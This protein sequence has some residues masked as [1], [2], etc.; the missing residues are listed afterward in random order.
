[1][2]RYISLQSPS[3]W[4]LWLQELT[5]HSCPCLP[6]SWVLAALPGMGVSRGSLGLGWASITVGRQLHGAWRVEPLELV[7]AGSPWRGLL[8]VS[9]LCTFQKQWSWWF[10]YTVSN[11]S[12][13]QREK[14]TMALFYPWDDMSWRICVTFSELQWAN[15]QN[16]F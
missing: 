9:S 4:G 1:M 3:F 5:C 15:P 8:T 13:N 16:H 11:A 12:S 2:T 7:E 10:L 6:E 14:M